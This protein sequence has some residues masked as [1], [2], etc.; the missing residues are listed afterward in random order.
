MKLRQMGTSE[1]YVSEV[2]LGCEHLEKMETADVCDIIACALDY[3]VNLLEVFMPGAKVR[4]DIAKAIANRRGQVSLIG[5]LGSA[6]TADGQYEC[7]RDV[8]KSV[9]HVHDFLRR[10][11]VDAVDILM[12]HFVDSQADL[13]VVLSPGGLMDQALKMKA[14]GLCRAIGMSSHVPAV[15]QRAV[16]TG[17]LQALLFPVNAA[18]DVSDNQ[19]IDEY[20]DEKHYGGGARGLNEA[21]A[22][23]YHACQGRGVGIVAMKPYMAGWLL[24]GEQASPL[25]IALTPAQCLHYALSQPG[26]CCAVPGVRSVDEVHAAMAYINASPQQRDYSALSRA[27]LWTGRGACAYCNHCLPCPE[28]IDIGAVTRL[29]DSASDGMSEALRAAYDALPVPASRCV[30]CGACEGRC[31]FSVP[32]SANMKRAAQLFE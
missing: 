28:N 6:L 22:R 3:G 24:K 30:A 26:V 15:A 32:A 18:G 12:L 8:K 31:P 11:R 23:L 25:G 29:C 4:D 13:D 21:R 2:S 14:Q 20:F 7:S 17:Q 19:S 16:E 9:E 5:H 27:K 1:L 10:M